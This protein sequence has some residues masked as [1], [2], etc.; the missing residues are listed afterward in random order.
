MVRRAGPQKEGPKKG[1]S[2]I[3]GVL[4]TFEVGLAGVRRRRVPRRIGL[5]ARRRK[6]VGA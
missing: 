4:R 6:R 3:T 5:V 2:A 1:Q